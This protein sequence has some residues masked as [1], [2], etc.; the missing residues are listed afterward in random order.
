MKR[1]ITILCLSDLHLFPAENM[2]KNILDK[3]RGEIK[4]LK[5]KSPAWAPD[6]IVIAG[7]LV[8]SREKNYQAV[9]EYLSLFIN[10][11]SFRLSPF[12]IIT[13]PGNHDKDFPKNRQESSAAIDDSRIFDSEK[14]KNKKLFEA[15]ESGGD[16]KFDLRREYKNNFKQFGEFYREYVVPDSRD[17]KSIGEYDYPQ[18]YLGNELEDIAL[19]SGI[20]VFHDSKTCFFCINT[21]WSYIP[22]DYSGDALKKRICT[23]VV[24]ESIK[25]IKYKYSDY[26]IVTVMHRNPSAFC[27]EERNAALDN[28]PDILRWLYQY[29]DVILTGHEHTEKILPPHMME[30]H[31]QLFQLGSAA[32]QGSSNSLP[33]YSAALIHLDPIVGELGICNLKY[34]DKKDEWSSTIDSLRYPLKRNT[35]YYW[36][37]QK[38]KTLRAEQSSALILKIRSAGNEDIEEAIRCSYLGIE[39]AS[40]KII[41][42][43]INAFDDL[44]SEIK[45]EHQ[46]SGSTAFFIYSLSVLDHDRFLDLKQKILEDPDLRKDMYL[47]KL[48]IVEVVFDYHMDLGLLDNAS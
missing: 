1:P 27:W 4:T 7:D 24:R 12:R 36:I 37:K 35:S 28:R 10:D 16:F 3:L 43:H 47:K 44:V 30:N 18:K 26:T 21:E 42:Q 25:Q 15:I 41:C 29:S 23:P 40:Y 33:Q 32:V 9:K 5:G 38:Q 46:A 34:D 17:G 8:D 6:Y 20:K 39:D 45:R 22:D 19:T 2:G 13:V 48:L 31:A 11:F 14:Q